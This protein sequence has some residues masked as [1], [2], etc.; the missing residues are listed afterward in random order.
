MQSPVIM[1]GLMLGAALQAQFKKLKGA[2]TRAVPQAVSAAAPG[3]SADRG[4]A[5]R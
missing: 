2:I 5:V 3:R 1:A 4:S